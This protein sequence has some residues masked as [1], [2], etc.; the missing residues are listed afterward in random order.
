MKKRT[1]IQGAVL[2]L[3]A[4][5]CL[6]LAGIGL[7]YFITRGRVLNLRPLVLIHHPVHLDKVEA[8][9]G[10][11]LHATAR[12]ENG[13]ERMELWVDDE[14][15]VVEEANDTSPTNMV[16][17]TTW[18]PQ[19]PGMR[20]L[21]AI[22]V[23]GEGV[24]GRST[25]R[26]NVVKTTA[27]PE[28]ANVAALAES[29][30]SG[31]EEV[32]PASPGSPSGTLPSLSP[33]GPPAPAEESPPPG[34]SLA[35]FE[36]L[37]LGPLFD[38]DLLGGGSGDPTTLRVEVLSLTTGTAY[39]GLH[40]YVGMAGASPSWIPDE[41]FDPMTDESFDLLGAGSW[42]IA[43][44]LAGEAAESILW[45]DDTALPLEISCV[46]IS[47]GGTDALELGH[48][49]VSIP[50]E[51]W[52]ET[53]HMLEIDGEEGSYRIEYRVGRDATPSRGEPMYLDPE[54]TSPSNLRLDTQSRTL[55]WDYL[56]EEDEEPI[57][58]FRFY[59]NGNLQ[60]IE[61][62][63]ARE[64]RLPHEW[65]NPPCETTYIFSVT[66]FRVGYPDG[67]ESFP[68]I[69]SARNEEEDC[70]RR[71]Q[72]TFLTLETH[73]LGGDGRHE[74]RHGDVGPPYGYFFGN[75]KQF[76]FDARPGGGRG[77]SLDMA[78]GFSHNT[79]YDLAAL[80]S[81]AGWGTRE[82]PSMIVEVPFGG[83]FEFGF[84]IM[85][86]DTGRC[87]DSGD[88]GCDDLIC[89]AISPIF[90]DRYEVFDHIQEGSLT[91]EDG[92]CTVSYMFRPGF[93]SPVGSGE[94]GWEPLPWIDVE[95][96][97]ILEPSGAVEIDIR[98]TGTATWPWKDLEIELQTR[99]GTPLGLFTWEEFVLEAGERTTLSDPEMVVDPPYDACIVID[100]NDAVL[101]DMERLGSLIH[102]PVC[103]GLPDLTI[104]DVIFDP[105]GG[106]RLR[107]TVENIGDS[108]LEGRTLEIKTFLPDGE[109]AYTAV[110]RPDISLEPGRSRV[111]DLSGV[112]ER[113]RERL[114]G[115]YTAIVNPDVLFAE[116]NYDN[117]E[118]VVEGP[119]Q[120]VLYWCYKHI[121][122]VG[123][124]PAS[125]ARM[126]FTADIV[127]GEGSERVL[128]TSW[129]EELRL[130][131]S[132]WGYSHSEHGFPGSWYQ[133]I[134]QTDPFE[135]RGDQSLQTRI[136]ATYRTGY[137]GD[138]VNIGSVTNV[139]GP[140][141]RWDSGP[142]A[143]IEESWSPCDDVRHH[144]VSHAFTI[145]LGTHTWYSMY[146]VCEIT[147]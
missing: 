65:F 87:R 104:T 119:G 32:Q 45:P 134:R 78:N 133:C 35:V 85:D 40:C 59:L 108:P 26:L 70:N 63:R 101:E 51:E 29:A 68:G 18:V 77:G 38:R 124:T 14:L 13:L 81:D 25:I 106:G 20:V 27:V 145:G 49:S 75:D 76:A 136:R 129:E 55:Q 93:D 16:V 46:A 17:T 4:V 6:C 28:V 131:E 122:R 57:D 116:S 123:D 39:E 34:S 89:E 67:P 97:R 60:W 120:L 86:Q 15:V 147:P 31:E 74:D 2:G 114:S 137:T 110:E 109:P 72:I 142:L 135:M 139:H 130:Q 98:N 21:T 69:T 42:D 23:S 30:L 11:I 7:T 61:N 19:I 66:A 132:R 36:L 127:S 10:L 125:A 146:L 107:V 52:D 73:N 115:G 94:A 103:P 144:P 102:T 141:A 1:L 54:M 117:N 105:S 84:H 12:L 95:D 24:T 3:I 126:Y 47:S 140:A 8:G 113:Q 53:I 79:V 62:A 111:F 143:G 22:A 112:T 121:P 71:I 64:T 50:P 91:S 80:F 128:D 92:R 44:H 41:D 56:P 48:A 37:G 88:R 118:F 5:V 82:A 138:F 58:G 83:T 9:E 90:E 96:L 100:P 99:E 33:G 43:E